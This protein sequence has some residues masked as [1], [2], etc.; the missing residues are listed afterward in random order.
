VG[1]QRETVIL[2]AGKQVGCAHSASPGF[3][4]ALAVVI[5]VIEFLSTPGSQRIQPF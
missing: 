1:A 2:S 4:L 5:A 3:R